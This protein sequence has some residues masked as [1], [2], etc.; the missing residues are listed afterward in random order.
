MSNLAGHHELQAALD[1]SL[2]FGPSYA[3]SSGG[4]L[5]S[6]LPMVLTALARLG[7]PAAALDRQ[8]A[9]WG[10]RLG[11]ARPMTGAPPEL[12]DLLLVPEALAFHGAIRLAYARDAGH[13]GEQATAAAVWAAGL[14]PLGPVLPTV[15]GR[16]SLRETLDAVRAEAALALAPR[17]SG[18]IV[19]AM[20][21]AIT[22]PGVANFIALPRLDLDSLAEAALAVYL[23]T[24]DF[25]ALHLVTGTHALRVLL[26]ATDDVDQAQVLRHFWRA[27]LAAYLSIGRPAPAWHLV[28]AGQ[29]GEPDWQAAL[30]ALF[31]SLDDHRIKLADSAREEWRLRAW[32][33]YM[34]AIQ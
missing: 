11:P 29:V 33:G 19:A 25:T 13:A 22:L 2:R 16:I 30:P 20:N 24:R 1:A 6:H 28:H 27:W 10:P 12:R 9:H 17:S 18:T 7:A 31:T 34:L 3:G 32:P 4:A 14:R 26:G 23:A 15:A 5:S 21:A 8:L